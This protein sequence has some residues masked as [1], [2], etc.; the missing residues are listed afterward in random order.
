MPLIT[1]RNWNRAAILFVFIMIIA[2]Y[3]A[4]LFVDV[5]R[6]ASKYAVIARGIHESGD[7]INIKVNGEPYLQ[8][9]PLMLFS[10]MNS[11]IFGLLG[12]PMVS[13]TKS[14]NFLG[15]SPFSA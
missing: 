10:C 6:D 13:A 8:K 5:T 1:V 12:K 9:P 15:P 3:V 2:T 4:G 14:M 7:F 11:H